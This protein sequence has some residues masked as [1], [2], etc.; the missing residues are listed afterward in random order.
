M[1]ICPPDNLGMRTFY[2]LLGDVLA[3]P[4]GDLIET[5]TPWILATFGGLILVIMAYAWWAAPAY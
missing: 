3:R 1:P 2:D 5:L 4:P